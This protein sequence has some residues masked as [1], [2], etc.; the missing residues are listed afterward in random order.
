MLGARN[1][2]VLR[3]VSGSMGEVILI[4]FQRCGAS[5]VAEYS[6]N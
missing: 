5:M 6:R 3:C 2:V 4:G 1:G